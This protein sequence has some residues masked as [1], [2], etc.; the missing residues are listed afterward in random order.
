MGVK[1]LLVP[2]VALLVVTG[3]VLGL[4]SGVFGTIAH[5]GLVAAGLGT[6]AASGAASSGAL[7]PSATGTGR[8]RGGSTAPSATPSSGSAGSVVLPAP[9]LAGTDG[10]GAVSAAAVSDLVR[11]VKVKDSGGYSG[12][13]RDMRTGAVVFSHRA[14]SGAI[15]ASTTKL[16]TTATAL[17][18][19]GAEHRFTT[20]VVSA[21]RGR[22]VLVGG[23]DPYLEEKSSRAQPTRASLG[24]LA[25][26]TARALEKDGVK[27]VSLDYDASLFSGPARNPTWPATYGD[28]ASD[29][30]A[31][32]VNE[33]RSTP[34]GG[35][36][37][38]RVSDPAKDAAKAFADRLESEGID[39]G[40]VGRGR[41]ARGATR[42]AAVSSMT[43]E[44]IVEHVLM[45][46]DNDGAEVL[47][48]QAAVAAHRPGTS[49]DGTAVVVARLK[50]LGAWTPGVRLVDG[51]G[52]SR[53]TRIPAATLTK[54][55]R[56]AGEDAHP[57]LRPLLTGL[58]VAGVEG[59]LATKFGDDE[60]LAGRGV[61][62]GK[63]GTLSKVHGLAGTITTRD[64]ALLA[65]A[66][67][68]NDPKNDYNATIWLDR[69]T[70]AISTC[71]CR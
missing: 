18:L 69:V 6:S 19:L 37:G 47:L 61:V 66:F 42:V 12:E 11:S 35:V 5:R 67:L 41:A 36:L 32:W 34:G 8:T 20:S 45:T 51:S 40:S 28:V 17:D 9:V 26:R 50:D 7:G 3:L 53:S 38:P 31:L 60:S 22:I 25:A 23:G 52:L 57:R 65:Y 27:K 64:G 62:R 48:R 33:G 68:V 2:V 4:V 21:G 58:P 1:R 10:Q 54:L 46:S 14:G 63:T 39:V 56:A 16:V 59:S 70:A 71:G 44:R 29:V 55:L 43:L 49:A 15:P 24:V 13:V 30:S